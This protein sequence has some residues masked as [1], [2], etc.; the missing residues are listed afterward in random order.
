MV[1]NLFNHLIKLLGSNDRRLN[2][3]VLD[4]SNQSYLTIIQY[5]QSLLFKSLKSQ[6]LG[7]IT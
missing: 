2:I 3:L 6:V 1:S 4:K 5:L 7:V